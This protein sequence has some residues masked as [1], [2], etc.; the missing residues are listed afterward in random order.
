MHRAL[1]NSTC[2]HSCLLAILITTCAPHLP[3]STDAP[4]SIIEP[5]EEHSDE[6]QIEV[7]KTLLEKNFREQPIAALITIQNYSKE[8][9]DQG[10][11]GSYVTWQLECSVIDTYKGI[12]KEV[13]LLPWTA[14]WLDGN[15]KPSPPPAGTTL[16][17]SLDYYEDGNGTRQYRLPDVAYDLPDLPELIEAARTFRITSGA[18][19]GEKESATLLSR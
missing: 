3:A 15:E 6:E 2:L 7:W 5:D 4:V 1:F 19:A 14:E 13:I 18:G 8:D 17:V 12:L 16:I 11:G 9:I 10:Q